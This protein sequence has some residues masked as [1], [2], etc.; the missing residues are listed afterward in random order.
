MWLLQEL[1]AMVGQEV[2]DP[3]SLLTLEPQQRLTPKEPL[4]PYFL[5][6]STRSR[7]NGK[8]LSIPLTSRTPGVEHHQ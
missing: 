8:K 2:W 6:S 4:C 1:R 5:S 7:S 3:S